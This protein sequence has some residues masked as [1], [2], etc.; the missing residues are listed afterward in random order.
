M[1]TMMWCLVCIYS[2]LGYGTAF[3]AQGH[4]VQE[5][6]IHS[7]PSRDGII[8]SKYIW[9]F[10]QRGGKSSLSPI[11]GSACLVTH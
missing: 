7:L 1:R 9:S 2:Y 5:D 8:C 3:L 4:D 6:G 11:G 10:S